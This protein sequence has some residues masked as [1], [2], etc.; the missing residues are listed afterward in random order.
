MREMHWSLV[1]STQR[2]KNASISYIFF[3]VGQPKPKGNAQV[4]SNLERLDA[5]VIG[6][7]LMFLAPNG[8]HAG[9]AKKFSVYLMS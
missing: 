9:F 6:K 3:L 8:F 4:A 1:G 5:Y 2:A 7:H